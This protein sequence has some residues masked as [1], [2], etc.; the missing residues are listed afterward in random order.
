VRQGGAAVPAPKVEETTDTES[1]DKLI[2][3][4]KASFDFWFRTR[5]EYGRFETSGTPPK[6]FGV[7]TSYTP[8]VER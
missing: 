3:A 2:V 6:D 7:K 5:C 4:L 1:K 8:L